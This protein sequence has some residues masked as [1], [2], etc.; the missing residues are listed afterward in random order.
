MKERGQTASS[1]TGHPTRGNGLPPP[2]R[3]PLTAEMADKI[4]R[5]EAPFEGTRYKLLSLVGLKQMP[6]SSIKQSLAQA[7]EAPRHAFAYISFCKNKFFL[8]IREEIIPKLVS[9]EQNYKRFCFCKPIISELL[10]DEKQMKKLVQFKNS[11]INKQACRAIN[12][13]LKGYNESD[14]LKLN[15]ILDIPGVEHEMTAPFRLNLIQ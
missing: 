2:K 10:G 9:A 1:R 3:K 5:G 12:I 14:P 15:D 7:A 8:F 13:L 6:I 4:L 11:Q